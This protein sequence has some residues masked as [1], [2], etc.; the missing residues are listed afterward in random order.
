MAKGEYTPEWAR[1]HSALVDF[2]F[3]EVQ[4]EYGQIFQFLK[5]S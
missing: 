2:H 5:S 4:P 3:V 1:Q